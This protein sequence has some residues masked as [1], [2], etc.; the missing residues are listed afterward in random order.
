MNEPRAWVLNLDAESELEAPRNYAPTRHLAAIVARE[1]ER[2]IGTLVAPQDLLVTDEVVAAVRRAPGGPLAQRLHGLA[3]YAWCPTPR[4]LS[5]L[6]AV[7]ARP[8][9]APPLETLRMAN[10][11][12]FAALVR[13]PLQ[14]AS[15]AK[16]GVA[17]LE[18]VL[19]AL[20]SPAPHGW[21]VRRSYGAAGRGRR[22]IASGRPDA[23]ELAWLVASLRLGPLIVEPW[24]EIVREHTRSAWIDVAG[25]VLISQP[26]FQQVNE[27]GAWTR[28]ECAELGAVERE[29][30]ERLEEAVEAAGRALA[31]HGYRGPFGIDA[32]RH[33]ALDGSGRTVL[34][35]LSEINARYTMDWAL[36]MGE[37]AGFTVW[38]S[39][40]PTASAARRVP[41]HEPSAGRR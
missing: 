6:H 8:V 39:D 1:R 17:A 31:A 37:R 20:A 38:S 7:G 25:T 19:D 14:R 40:R 12:P 9:A 33:R 26:C 23:G 28:T 2:L 21:L 22:R 3:G 32:Y 35:P 29:D 27:H 41:T 36:A 10:A 24:V 16:R 18:E 34:N 5:M 13:E 15:L 11:R 4:A 30:D